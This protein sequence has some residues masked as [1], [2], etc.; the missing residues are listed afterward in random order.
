[1]DNEKGKE[2][3][4]KWEDG[5]DTNNATKVDLREYLNTKLYQYTLYRISDENLWDLFKDDFKDFNSAIF[6]QYSRTELQTLRK[7][8]Q[9]SGVHIE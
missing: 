8:L 5:I 1:M 2:L 6:G 9:Y 3:F 4:E 7:Y